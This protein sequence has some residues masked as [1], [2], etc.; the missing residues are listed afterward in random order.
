MVHGIGVHGGAHVPQLRGIVVFVVEPA[1]HWEQYVQ[2][3]PENWPDGQ[4]R[5]ALA[6]VCGMYVPSVQ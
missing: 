1:G 3:I 2:Y 5:H 4:F 6:L